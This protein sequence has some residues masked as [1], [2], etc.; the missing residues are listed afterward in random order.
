[1]GEGGKDENQRPLRLTQ[2]RPN[3]TIHARRSSGSADIPPETPSHDI[4]ELGILGM[5]SGEGDLNLYLSQYLFSRGG[6]ELQR[7]AGADMADHPLPDLEPTLSAVPQPRPDLLYGYPARSTFTPA[8]LLRLQGLH[9][10]IPDYAQACANPYFPFF[11]VEMEGVAGAGGRLWVVANQCGF[12][13][14]I[15]P[16]R[17]CTPPS[18]RVCHSGVVAWPAPE[19][20]P[21]S[22]GRYGRRSATDIGI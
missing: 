5:S 3:S 21:G 13:P 15:Q 2:F 14:A 11:A 8:Q 18:A 12:L 20:Y 17:L 6:R 7:L 16:G 9:D 4:D 22:L 10:Q 19:E 1:M